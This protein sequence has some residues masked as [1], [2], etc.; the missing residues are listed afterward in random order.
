ML[1]HMDFGYVTR[2]QAGE[3]RRVYYEVHESAEVPDSDERA[4]VASLEAAGRRV[5][6]FY[7]REYG[8][9]LGTIAPDE[10]TPLTREEF[11]AARDA[12]WP[13]GTVNRISVGG[14][15]TVSNANALAPPASD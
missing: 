7:E 8:T 6:T 13:Q 1:A 15:L 12:G 14:G 9:S 4:R 5:V 3:P 11:E 10:G 2:T